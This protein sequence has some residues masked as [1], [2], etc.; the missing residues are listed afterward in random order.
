MADVVRNPVDIRRSSLPG[1]RGIAQV[2]AAQHGVI[3]GRQLFELGL[4]QG[5][6]RH[7]V[8]AGRLHRLYGGVHAVYA[9]G[10]PRLSGPGR[11]MAAVLACGED[12][13]LSHRSAAAHWGLA[14][15]AASRI[16][17]TTS[18]RGRSERQSIVLHRVRSFDPADRA[19][20]D[21][22]PLT[23]IPR[24]LLDYA[25][26]MSPARLENA[27]EAAERLRLLDVAAVTELCERSRGRRGLRPLRALLGRYVDTAAGTRSPLERRFTA[28]CRAAGLPPPATNVVIAGFEVDALWPR[29]RL[30]V[31]VDSYAYHRTRG[32]FERDRGRDRQL[33]LAGYRVVRITDRMLE[34][35]PGA[36][37]GSIRMLL[38]DA[39]STFRP[40]PFR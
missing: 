19:L 36:V 27:F 1:D 22:I 5:A 17:V 18:G 7:R 33:Q 29:E 20:R 21:A 14:P 26:V 10:N 35:E 37:A 34:G 24:T 28:F 8:A 32:A 4:R 23:T 31:E 15:S 16:D 9:V 40:A 39:V 11:W 2:A 38:A 12:A 6:I 30:V 13:V 3:G 25:E